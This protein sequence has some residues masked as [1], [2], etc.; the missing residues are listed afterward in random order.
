MSTAGTAMSSFSF[1]RLRALVVKEGLQIVRDP[2]AL[3]IAVV[4]PVVLL[5]LFAYA[6]SLDIRHVRIGVVD[7]SGGAASQ[8][9]AAAFSAT[10][11]FAVSPA[12]DRREV[13]ERV[14]AGDLRGLVVIPQDF[15][16]RLLTGGDLPLVQIITDGT[17]PNTAAFVDNYARGTVMAWQAGRGQPRDGAGGAAIELA[18]RFW[19]NPEID[20]RRALVPGAMAIVMTI[21]GTILTALVVAREWERGTIEAVMSTP[22]TVS[23]ILLGK[24]IP[25]FLLGLI[26]TIGASL[27]AIHLF[28]VPL[29][30]SWGALL[31]LTAAFLV[32]ALGQGLLISVLARNQFVASQLALMAG[33]LPAFLLSGYLFEIS[34]MPAPI[35]AFTMIIPARYFIR[36]LQTVYLAGDVWSVFI[37]DILAMLAIGAV[38]LTLS[39]VK[40]RKSLDT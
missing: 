31:L 29:R 3:L 17:Q 2:S 9:L 30:G 13:E 40:S 34:S 21:I 39:R 14:F 20:S 24:L 8:S 18:Q 12:H 11:Y 1:R 37:P 35:R 27:L 6:V 36:S 16:A 5:F 10:T 19:Y 23:E 25:Y 7:E 15:D 28:D 32:P 33:F 38:L 4:L 26:A 22:A